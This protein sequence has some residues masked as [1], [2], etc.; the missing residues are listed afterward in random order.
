MG[1]EISDAMTPGCILN[2]DGGWWFC[3]NDMDARGP[4]PDEAAARAACRAAGIE[5]QAGHY[6]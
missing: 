1:N 2:R 3:D 4:Y 6:L 5:P